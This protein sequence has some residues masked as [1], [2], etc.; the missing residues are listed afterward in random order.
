MGRPPLGHRPMT[1]TERVRRHRAMQE[2]LAAGRAV[3]IDRINDETRAALSGVPPDERTRKLEAKAASWSRFLV[4][5]S[6]GG[7]HLDRDTRLLLAS[8]F[9]RM[10]QLSEDHALAAVRQIMRQMES[11]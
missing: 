10:E 8:A 7:G 3:K 2:A 9:A 5:Q 4:T 1:A 11:W 6:A